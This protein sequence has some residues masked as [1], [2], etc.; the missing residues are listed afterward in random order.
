MLFRHSG[1]RSAG[2]LYLIDDK[3]PSGPLHG[4]FTT[5][6]T[7]FNLELRSG[8]M[9]YGAPSLAYINSIPDLHSV[10]KVYIIYFRGPTMVS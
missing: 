9:V 3:A 1:K 5:T 6:R 7:L 8:Y 4:G 10:H 2:I